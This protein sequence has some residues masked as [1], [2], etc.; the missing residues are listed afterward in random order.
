MKHVMI[1]HIPKYNVYSKAV[2]L[3]KT[4]DNETAN[5]CLSDLVVWGQLRIRFPLLLPSY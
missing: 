2:Q 5:L 4:Y 1:L 3:K